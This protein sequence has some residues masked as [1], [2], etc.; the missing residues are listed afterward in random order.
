MLAEAEINAAESMKS[1]VSVVIPFLPRRDCN[2]DMSGD[3]V[4]NR[5][6][7]NYLFIRLLGKNLEGGSAE[8]LKSFVHRSSK[9][10]TRTNGS[11]V[12]PASGRGKAISP[13]SNRA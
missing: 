9:S 5:N 4:I 8:C 3:K 13:E 12:V 2:R 6:L 7:Q 1:G 10:T 11:E